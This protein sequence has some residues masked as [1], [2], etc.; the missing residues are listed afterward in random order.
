MDLRAVKIL[1]LDPVISLDELL[2]V[3]VGGLAR[4]DLLETLRAKASDGE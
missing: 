2:G 3:E 4:E 1:A